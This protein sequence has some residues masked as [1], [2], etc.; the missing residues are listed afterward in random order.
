SLLNQASHT[1]TAPTAQRHASASPRFPYIDF[2]NARINFKSVD[3]K[4][5]FSFFNCDLSIWLDQP[6]EWRLRFEGQ[7]ARTDL[8]L[9]LSDSGLIRVDGSLGR[10]PSLDQ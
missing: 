2:R 6:Q 4:Q 1:S 8:D 10:A 5:P 9:D 7:P 3:E